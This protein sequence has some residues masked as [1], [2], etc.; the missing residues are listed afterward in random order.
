MTDE[1]GHELFEKTGIM[2]KDRMLLREALTH[3]SSDYKSH[4]ER[5]EFLGDSLLSFLAAENIYKKHTMLREG[6][7]STKKT[8]IVSRENLVN[9]FDSLDIG[10]II[11]IDRKSF[12]E[13][14]PDSIKEDIIESIMAAAY[15]DG[16]IRLARKFFKIILAN[17]TGV[18]EHF[19]AKNKL[20]ELCVKLFSQLPEFTVNPSDEGFACEVLVKG[21]RYG[22]SSAQSKKECEKKAALITIRKLEKEH[23]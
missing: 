10:D 13:A 4:Y 11:H 2:I 7:L 20:Q 3:R 18:S 17:S 8:E 1:K 16:G 19:F 22:R 15:L 21:K 9:V 12:R 14:I 6:E 5:M 23:K